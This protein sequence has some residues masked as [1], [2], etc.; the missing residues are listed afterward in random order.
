MAA[1]RRSAARSMSFISQGSCSRSRGA[2][3][4][5]PALAESRYPRFHSTWAAGRLILNCAANARIWSMLAPGRIQ[6]MRRARNPGISVLGEVATHGSFVGLIV[7]MRNGGIDVIEQ[8]GEFF[9][10]L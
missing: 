9:V 3:R 10:P 4:K 8:V 6:R 1:S 2:S 7:G 5:A